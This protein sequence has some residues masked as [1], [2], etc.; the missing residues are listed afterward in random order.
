M[1]KPAII[2]GI[3]ILKYSIVTTIAHC[4]VL[5]F[6]I[7]VAYTTKYVWQLTTNPFM[8]MVD[9]NKLNADLGTFLQTKIPSLTDLGY[10]FIRFQKLV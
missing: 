8:M 5:T 2:A 1:L 3:A 6:R 7:E 10:V 4:S 9:K